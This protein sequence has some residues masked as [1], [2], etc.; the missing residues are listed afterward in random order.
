MTF[1]EYLWKLLTRPFKLKNDTES[2]CYVDVLGDVQEEAKRAMFKLRRSWVVGTATGKALDLLGEAR[3]IRR[4][5]GEADASLQRRVDSAYEI[6]MLGGTVPGM[7]QGLTSLGFPDSQILEGQ[8]GLSWAE[9]VVVLGLDGDGRLDSAEAYC[10][11][12]ETLCLTKAAHTM[13]ARLQ[14]Q[15]ESKTDNYLGFAKLIIGNTVVCPAQPNIDV[16]AMAD[17]GIIPEV[18][19]NPSVLPRYMASIDAMVSVGMGYVLGGSKVIYL[20]EKEVIPE[21]GE[22]DGFL[23]LMMGFAVQSSNTMMIE[24]AMPD[25]FKTGFNMG[26]LPVNSDI[27]TIGPSLQNNM[28]L[29]GNIGMALIRTDT[30]IIYAE[31]MDEYGGI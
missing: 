24:P 30:K 14:I 8:E 6:Y 16:K 7:L 26:L 11:I 3:G 9:F 10:R 2:K 23:S 5:T 20:A 15:R 21:I 25:E 22:R 12:W 28:N 19:S 1:K 13:P 27:I 29:F 18:V 17:V 31:E 4:Y